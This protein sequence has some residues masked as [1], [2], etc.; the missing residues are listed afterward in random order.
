MKARVLAATLVIAAIYF[1]VDHYDHKHST[2][3]TAFVAIIVAAFLFLWNPPPKH[4]EFGPEDEG[5]VLRGGD[6][7][8]P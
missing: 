4:K 6:G 2:A 1:A 5:E 8:H 3:I 7:S